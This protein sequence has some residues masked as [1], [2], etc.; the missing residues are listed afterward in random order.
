MSS[1][2]NFGTPEHWLARAQA[3]R[4]T[5][6][7]MTDPAARQA[8][9]DIAENYEKIAKRAEARAAGIPIHPG[10]GLTRDSD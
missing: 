2:N 10:G 7:G 5:A 8:M 3:A 1:N 4:E 6:A 9:L